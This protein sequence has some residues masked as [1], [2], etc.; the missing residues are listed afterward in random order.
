MGWL[1][2][3]WTVRG[4]CAGHALLLAASFALLAFQAKPRDT[5]AIGSII[6]SPFNISQDGKLTTASLMSQYRRHRFLLQI[7]AKEEAPPYRIASCDVNANN[8]NGD[9]WQVWVWER[10]DLVRV[11]LAQPPEEVM[12]YQEDVIAIL[13]KVII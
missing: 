1:S 6:P 8:I 5:K 12:Q 2:C 3:D 7:Q 13:S 4:V 11:V 9:Y 10:E